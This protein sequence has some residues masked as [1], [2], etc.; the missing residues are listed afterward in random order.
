MAKIPP[1]GSVHS[2]VDI[3]AAKKKQ[4]DEA[5]R[6]QRSARSRKTAKQRASITSHKT[7]TSAKTTKQS[8]KSSTTSVRTS[9]RTRNIPSQ[10][11]RQ[12]TP[13]LDAVNAARSRELIASFGQTLITIGQVW[14][15]Q[16]A[17][18]TNSQLE[19]SMEIAIPSLQAIATEMGQRKSAQGEVAMSGVVEVAEK[20]LAP[21]KNVMGG[22]SA[23]E[24]S[25][26]GDSQRKLIKLQE[27]VLRRRRRTRTRTQT[28]GNEER[29]WHVWVVIVTVAGLEASFVVQRHQC[30]M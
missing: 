2:S 3:Y 28:E 26:F 17:S 9:Y 13:A 24:S 8:R 10:T 15:V 6:K 25:G 12:P 18:M 1:P 4:E 19:R 5:R 21:F 16:S 22:E 27:G 29:D 23:G 7:T 30:R 20:L 14:L 11:N